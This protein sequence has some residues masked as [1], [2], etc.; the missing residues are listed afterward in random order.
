[1]AKHSHRVTRWARWLATFVGFPAAGVTARLCVGDIDST[2]AALLGGLAGGAVLG[3]I[4]AFVG[5]IEA[6]DRLRWVI[7]TAFG[8][9]FGLAV[10]TAVVDFGT[11]SRSLAVMGAVCGAVVGLAQALSVPMA[12]RDRV[13]WAI[14]MPPLWAAGWLVTARVI[15]DADRH[16]A[17]FGASGALVVSALS[18]I[19][20]VLRRPSVASVGSS[21]RTSCAAGV[22]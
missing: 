20:V 11:D 21:A 14:A 17:T 13:A 22:S 9:G 15:V 4:Q 10:G 19:L 18:G 3:A 6:R 16:H 12:G 1:M 8:L 5:G 2:R 7:A